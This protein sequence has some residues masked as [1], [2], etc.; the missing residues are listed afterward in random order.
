MRLEDARGC[1]FNIQKFSVHDG[2]G[3]RTLVFLKGC[4]LRCRW[5]SNPESQRFEVELSRDGKACGNCGK[6]I[7]VCTKGALAWKEGTVTLD[8][9]ACHPDGE[10]RCVLACENKVYGVYGKEYSA[11]E[12][13]RKIGDD[14][15][16]Y[17]RS[18]GGLTVGG[19]EPLAQPEFCIALLK[20]ARRSG[21]NT[22][23]ETCACVKTE[24]LLEAASCLD[25]I[26]L[27]IKTLDPV[28][29]R[30]WTGHDNRLILDNI[31]Q[32][33]SAYPRL[34]LTIRTPVVPGFNDSAAEIR[35]ISRFAAEVGARYEPLR[36][37]RYGQPKY[38]RLGR[39]YPL[40]DAE[41][42]QS[43]FDSL[44]E[45]I[46]QDPSAKEAQA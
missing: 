39:N 12:I 31:R 4:P 45:A 22:N 30:E 3:I 11:G 5:C 44:K 14:E 19:G 21:I 16:F 28:K 26:Y 13:L 2:K 15:I 9:T 25:S 46:A 34:P 43:M 8:R 37:H 33:S 36:Y 10:C 40:G 38:V 29:H 32:L 18:G 20:L 23:M 35:A 27:D 6:C 24:H 7:S 17:R 42:V 41:V 1:I